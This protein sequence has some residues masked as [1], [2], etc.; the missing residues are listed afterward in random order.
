MLILKS[1]III[2]WDQKLTLNPKTFESELWTLTIIMLKVFLYCYYINSLSYIC[3]E[4]CCCNMLNLSKCK[5]FMW[6]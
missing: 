4:C 2:S 5:S 1:S 3:I 6:W